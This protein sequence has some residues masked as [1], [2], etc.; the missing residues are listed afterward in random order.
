M[1]AL[2]IVAEYIRSHTKYTVLANSG[3]MVTITKVL[4]GHAVYLILDNDA[5]NIRVDL[6]F[7]EMY[8][9]NVADPQAMPRIYNMVTTQLQ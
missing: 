3:H 9:V 4:F 8:K 5:T 6:N 7:T 1:N 2:T